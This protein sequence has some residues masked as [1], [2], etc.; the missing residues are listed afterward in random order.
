MSRMRRPPE[1]VTDDHHC[2]FCQDE[3]EQGQLPEGAIK[4]H[5]CPRHS[6]G[7]PDMVWGF[8]ARCEPVGGVQRGRSPL[9]RGRAGVSPA[10]HS[11][12]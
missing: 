11:S 2:P 3:V 9:W 10:T 4:E 8:E 5:N 7:Q 1:Y 12:Y 6:W